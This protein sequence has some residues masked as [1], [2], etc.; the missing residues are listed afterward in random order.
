MHQP[1]ACSN[2]VVLRDFG[3]KNQQNETILENINIDLENGDSLLIRGASGAGKTTMLK[4]IAGIYPFDTFGYAKRPCGAESL[5]LPQRPYMPQGT[6][7]EA[8][9]YP[10][11][12][13]NHPDLEDM[14]KEC[15]L[16]KYIPALDLDNDWQVLLSP[17]ELQRVVFIRILL[18]KPEVIFLDETT[19]ALDEPTETKL[20]RMIREQLPN[21]IILSVGHRGTLLQ[22]HNKQ[23]VL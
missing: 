2:R 10:R 8:I 11:I 21:A 22:F 20:Y 3:I 18:M 9:C 13:P 14:M 5:F 12:S 17:G 1:I 7:R 15:C 16:E 6:L 4:A 23:L 19:S